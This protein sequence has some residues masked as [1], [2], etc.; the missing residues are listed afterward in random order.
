MAISLKNVE[1]LFVDEEDCIRQAVNILMVLG[2][3]SFNGDL[4]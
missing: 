4:T 2:K 1:F 3:S